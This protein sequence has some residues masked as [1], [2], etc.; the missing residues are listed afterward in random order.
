MTAIPRVRPRRSDVVWLH[1]YADIVIIG[2]DTP[3]KSLDEHCLYD[4]R[5]HD[6][7]KQEDIDSVR[8]DGVLETCTVNKDGN[9]YRMVDGRGRTRRARVVCDE[10]IAAGVPLED[11]I[12]V[13]CTVVRGDDLYLMMLSRKLNSGRTEVTLYDMGLFAEV[14]QRKYQKTLAE[15]AAVYS[16]SVATIRNALA[17]LDLST[18]GLAALKSDI[19]KPTS[20]AL[21]AQLPREEQD[22]QIQEIKADLEKGIKP[23]VEKIN[24]KV[25]EHLGKDAAKTPRARV[26][27]ATEILT[28]FAD[29]YEKPSERATKEELTALLSDA[30]K[31]LGS[32]ARALSDKSLAKL[33]DTSD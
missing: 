30:V 1:P 25:R 22:R 4:P 7:L 19:L 3:H 31:A 18:E 12:R 32:I 2:I 27:R 15:I 20:A 14:M 6:A 13:P 33:A 10:Q 5:V 8:A 11:Q 17:L 24:D 26:G 23:T 29:K 9:K 28:K 16:V 21:F